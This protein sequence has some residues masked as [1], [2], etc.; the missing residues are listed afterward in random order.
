M[1]LSGQSQM[2]PNRCLASQGC[3]G[4]MRLSGQS[5]MSSNRLEGQMALTSPRLLK[6]P[7]TN[8][9]DRSISNAPLFGSLNRTC[10][11]SSCIG[12]PAPRMLELWKREWCFHVFFSFHFLLF[13]SSILPL[14][15]KSSTT[16]IY[17]LSFFFEVEL[18]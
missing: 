2:S 17:T 12:G 7:G 3:R 10:H 18:E 4:Q 8:D 9:I 14:F 5:Q 6:V 16:R 11:H 15:D 1:R 13:Y